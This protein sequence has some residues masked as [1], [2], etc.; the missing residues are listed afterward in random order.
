MS[1]DEI[2]RKKV[3]GEIA[4]PTGIYKI[5][6]CAISPKFKNKVWAKPYGGIIPRVMNIKELIVFLFIQIVK[7]RIV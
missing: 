3:Y 5:E 6:I 4:I 1:I 7:Q 2:K